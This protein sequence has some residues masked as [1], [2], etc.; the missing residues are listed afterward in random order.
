MTKQIIKAKMEAEQQV[1][2]AGISKLQV[3][4]YENLYDALSSGDISECN[5]H[6]SNLIN[7]S[8]ILFF[9]NFICFDVTGCRESSDPCPKKHGRKRG[10]LLVDLSLPLC[11][12]FPIYVV[13][14]FSDFIDFVNYQHLGESHH[15]S[16]EEQWTRQDSKS[17]TLSSSSD[18]KNGIFISELI[19]YIF[20]K[21][22]IFSINLFISYN[23]VNIVDYSNVMLMCWPRPILP[24]L[25]E[26]E[27][28]V[29]E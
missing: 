7:I 1:D 10:T 27:V 9:D 12:Q 29:R 22:F 26:E 6:L 15:F 14:H 8:N 2:V 3:I 16:P 24:P 13:T 20:L 17:Q 25:A 28:R 18:L 11:M 19:I 21:L 4:C 5:T 23:T